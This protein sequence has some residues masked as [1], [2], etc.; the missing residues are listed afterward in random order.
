[1]GK[2]LIICPNMRDIRE[3]GNINKGKYTFLY[4]DYACSEI[5][6]LLAKDLHKKCIIPDPEIAIKKALAK[7][8]NENLDGIF[9][10]DD[11]PGTIL[12]NI[13]SF[14][15][16]FKGIHPKMSLLSEQKYYSRQ[17]QK[18]VVPIVN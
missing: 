7:Y 16:G 3:L 14:E 8:K 15:L 6:D 11:Y 17:M 5:K 13:L 4:Y 12:A 10:T 18:E 9:S 2:I 1:M